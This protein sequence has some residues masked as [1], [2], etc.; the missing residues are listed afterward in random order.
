MNNKIKK[1]QDIYPD[2]YEVECQLKP[3]Q[4]PNE[5]FDNALKYSKAQGW[6]LV[7]GWLLV[8]G[9]QAIPHVW[10]KKDKTHRDT[11]QFTRDWPMH[12]YIYSPGVSKWLNQMNEDYNN[13]KVGEGNIH[14]GYE[15]K[16]SQWIWTCPYRACD[17]HF[18]K[19]YLGVSKD[20]YERLRNPVYGI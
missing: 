14:T 17:E 12:I 15:W 7:G 19:T 10:N 11:T 5:C 6:E 8:D 1:L 13:G 20:T 4:T 3:Q 18:Q 9:N 2:A 16:D